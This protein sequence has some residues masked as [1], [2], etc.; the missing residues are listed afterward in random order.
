MIRL[1][2]LTILLLLAGCAHSHHA[3]HQ[4]LSEDG[5]GFAP[6]SPHLG[7]P[8]DLMTPVGQQKP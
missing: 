2:A 5:Y 1:S 4:G 7:P 8:A 6:N 3:I